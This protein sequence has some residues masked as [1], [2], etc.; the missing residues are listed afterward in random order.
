VDRDSSVGVA[1]RYGP[2]GLGIQYWP[3][4][5]FLHPSRLGLGTTQ[6]PIHWV[7]GL[8]PR[9]SSGLG[10]ALITHHHLALRLKTVELNIYSMSGLSWSVLE[11]SL[12]LLSVSQ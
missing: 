2:D 3:G 12:P 1:T 10:V 8:F 9:G 5:D 4:R 7:P 11:T 6:P